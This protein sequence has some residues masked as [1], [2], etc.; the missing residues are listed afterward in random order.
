[1]VS[2][3]LLEGFGKGEIADYFQEEYQPWKVKAMINQGLF[4]LRDYLGSYE[5]D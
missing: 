5:K 4:Q 3:N 1:M 2:M